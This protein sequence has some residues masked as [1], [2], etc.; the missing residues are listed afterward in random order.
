MVGDAQALRFADAPFDHPMALLVMNFIPDHTKAI[1]EM[2]RVTRPQGTVSACVWDYAA[3]M[4]MLRFFWDPA[5][6]AR[7]VSS[8]AIKG[9]GT[10]RLA[11]PLAIVVKALANGLSAPQSARTLGAPVQP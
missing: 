6:V 2:R 1:A 8:V 11:F 10:L 9:R 5:V 7:C 4:Q 3:G